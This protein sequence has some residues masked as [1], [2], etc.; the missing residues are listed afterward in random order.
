MD[1]SQI[2]GVSIHLTILV[3]IVIIL[4]VDGILTGVQ[5]LSSTK[6]IRVTILVSNQKPLDRLG[7]SGAPIS[8]GWERLYEGKHK[9][10]WIVIIELHHQVL[11]TSNLPLPIVA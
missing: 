10:V 8:Q 1:S 11:I 9:I 5:S 4:Q 6:A 7:L 2:P 3:A